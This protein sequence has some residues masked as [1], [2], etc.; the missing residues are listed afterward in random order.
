MN[1]L[2]LT[3]LFRDYLAAR[4]YHGPCNLLLPK[5]AIDYRY[6]AIYSA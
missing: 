3:D 2:Y 4:S 1:V 6:R 5:R